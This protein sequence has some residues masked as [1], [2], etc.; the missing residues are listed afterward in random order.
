MKYK[1]ALITLFFPAIVFAQQEGEEV[2]MMAIEAPRMVQEAP[3]VASEGARGAD[4]VLSGI[5]SAQR[6]I[7]GTGTIGVET[8]IV[9]GVMAGTGVVGGG[10]MQGV[11]GVV[12]GG[13]IVGGGVMQGVGAVVTGGNIVGGGVMQGIGAI[14]FGGQ[15]VGGGVMQGVQTF[16]G[17]YDGFLLSEQA[18][19]QNL[20]GGPGNNPFLYF[21]FAGTEAYFGAEL[22]GGYLFEGGVG[23]GSLF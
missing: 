15:M 13:N 4:A 23:L 3:L 8:T 18:M 9:G 10:V 2:Q 12:T 17:V 20:S 19:N 7:G 11:G 14:V 5:G 22:F 6:N 21:T 1:L 16:T